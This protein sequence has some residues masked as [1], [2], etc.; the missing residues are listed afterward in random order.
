MRLMLPLQFALVPAMCLAG[1]L[2]PP[3]SD[4]HE[5]TKVKLD[6]FKPLRHVSS[7]CQTLK[8]PPASTSDCFLPGL[9][10]SAFCLLGMGGC[11]HALLHRSTIWKNLLEDRRYDKGDMPSHGTGKALPVSV[12]VIFN[13][14]GTLRPSQGF[15]EMQVT[16]RMKWTDPRLTWDPEAKEAALDIYSVVMT[17]DEEAADLIWRPDVSPIRAPPQIRSLTLVANALPPRPLQ[18]TLQNLVGFN[19]DRS[20]ST[21]VINSDGLIFWGRVFDGS[22]AHGFDFRWFPFGTSSLFDAPQSTRPVFSLFIRCELL[23]FQTHNIQL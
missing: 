17:I 22:F 19:A 3:D 18:V 15:A 16:C 4:A 8:P 1:V 9:V 20:L 6:H 21:T 2:I 5:D 23:Y 14:I 13:R 11:A 12:G 7:V 10:L